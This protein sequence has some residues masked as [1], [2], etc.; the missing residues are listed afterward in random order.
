MRF[1]FLDPTGEEDP[2]DL[3]ASKQTFGFAGPA[4]RDGAGTLSAALGASTTTEVFVLDA[5][6]VL[7]FRGAVSD[8]FAIGGA[9]G[10]E[11]REYL[12]DALDQ[13]L[14]GKEIAVPATSCL[15]LLPSRC[16]TRPT[17]SERP[18]RRTSSPGDR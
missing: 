16:C 10:G 4:L 15:R 13:L 2:A 6:G 3:A 18:P 5:G 14:A 12:A 7:R 9:T 11:P 8:A 17:N 1:L